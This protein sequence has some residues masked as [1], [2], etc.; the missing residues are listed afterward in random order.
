MTCFSGFSF[1][2][3]L[4]YRQLNRRMSSNRLAFYRVRG[5][6]YEYSRTIGMLT[7]DAIRERI[8]KDFSNLSTLFAFV[9]SDYGAKLHKGF[10]EAV[11][12]YYP[13]YWDE[14][15]GL[16]DGSEIPFEQ[17]LVLNFLNE[18]R[19][20]YRLQEEK[21]RQS[22]ENET[23]EKGCTT[24]LI[25]RTDSDVC[26]ILHNEDHATALYTTAYIIEADIQSSFYSDKQCYSPEE[27]FIAYSYA[28]SIPGKM[29]R[30]SPLTTSLNFFCR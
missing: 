29:E 12:S 26:S 13:W 9:Q 27:K 30:P 11:Q 16:A 21:H 1:V 6:H 10:Q 14:I 3:A 22:V 2:E 24:V 15:Q 20:A 17:I 8:E 5:T 19:T 4:Q 28:G 25:N 23:G 7:R 18:T